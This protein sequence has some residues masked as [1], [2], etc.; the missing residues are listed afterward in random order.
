MTPSE[1]YQ[2]CLCC[3]THLRKY[4]G[5][6]DGVCLQDQE[7]CFKIYWEVKKK[8]T[9]INLKARTLQNYFLH[10]V[11]HEIC[12][13]N[14]KLCRLNQQIQMQWTFTCLSRDQ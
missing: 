2:V 11:F 14:N 13:A 7:K 12:I 5:S 8:Q 6:T 4:A 10:T 3:L 9:E 1:I